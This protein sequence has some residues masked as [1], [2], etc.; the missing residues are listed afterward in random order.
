MNRY[1]Y[2]TVALSNPAEVSAKARAFVSEVAF[3]LE[4]PAGANVSASLASCS[5]QWALFAVFAINGLSE[6]EAETA[7]AAALQ[8]LRAANMFNDQRPI[9]QA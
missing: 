5:V 3:G 1:R 8:N 2:E 9:G 7:C 4:P 6:A